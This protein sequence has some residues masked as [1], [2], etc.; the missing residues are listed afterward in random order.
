MGEDRRERKEW[1]LSSKGLCDGG[2]RLDGSEKVTQ[3]VGRD[4]ESVEEAGWDDSTPARGIAEGKFGCSESKA[5]TRIVC[6]IWVEKRKR[7]YE[8]ARTNGIDRGCAET[9]GTVEGEKETHL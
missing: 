6:E 4:R 2:Q 8:G 1:G 7:R 5:T 3:R 9:E